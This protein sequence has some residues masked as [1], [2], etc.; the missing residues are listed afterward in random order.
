MKRIEWNWQSRQSCRSFAD[1][2]AFTLIELLT[3]VAILILLAAVSL[4]AMMRMRDNALKA[5][6]LSNLRQIAAAV[7]LYVGENNGYYPTMHSGTGGP[8]G[9]KA[10]YWTDQ[11]TPYLASSSSKPGGR[12]TVF[13][14][15]RFRVNHN[16]GGYGA[17]SF[18]INLHSQDPTTG[19]PPAISAA[20][21]DRPSKHLLAANSCI[22]IPGKPGELQ[23]VFFINATTDPAHPTQPRPY[24]VHP[25]ETF[26][27][28]FCDGHAEAI[29]YDFYKENKEQL[30]GPRPW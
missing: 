8:N 30:V 9:W 26:A 1:L 27:A 24:P 16:I 13:Y 3:V 29:A 11:I 19:K 4:P 6:D 18:A 12:A 10:P 2:A 20:R 15:P 25:G 21:I 28:V 7:P 22:P 5:A 23:A 17:N 14:S